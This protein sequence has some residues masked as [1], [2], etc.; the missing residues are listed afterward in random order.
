MTPLH[1]GLSFHSGAKLERVCNGPMTQREENAHPFEPGLG[2]GTARAKNPCTSMRNRRSRLGGRKVRDR[3]IGR[4]SVQRHP[5]RLPRPP[6]PMAAIA[7]GPA[8]L[9]A[10]ATMRGNAEPA[11]SK[12]LT[13]T[14]E[15]MAVCSGFTSITNAPLCRASSGM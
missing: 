9:N 5:K 6:C 1:N 14:N 10:A 2:E 13:S 3:G 7:C 15:V 4:P 11:F 12:M 8:H